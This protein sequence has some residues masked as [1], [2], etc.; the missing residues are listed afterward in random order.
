[1]S[2]RHIAF[3]EAD[4]IKSNWY[5]DLLAD[6]K[7]DRDYIRHIKK[8]IRKNEYLAPVIVV[9]EK[10]SYLIVNGHHRCFALLETGAKKIKCLVIAGTFADTEPLRKAE[11]LL[12]EYDKNTGYRYQFSGYLDRW[13]AAAEGHDFINRYRPTAGYFFLRFIRGILK[14]ISR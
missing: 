13:A 12:K 14:K 2:Q 3:I 7:P 4:K 1:M 9:K 10:E 11:L 8:R 6:W 5:N